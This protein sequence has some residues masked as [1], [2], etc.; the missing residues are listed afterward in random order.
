MSKID[1]EKS[2]EIHNVPSVGYGEI[3]NYVSNRTAQG[4]PALDALAQADGKNAEKLMEE[5]Q[6]NLELV[7]ETG[8]APE[9]RRNFGVISLLGVGFGL[10]NSWFGISASLVTGISSGGP[11]MIIYG[12]LIVACIS[13][14]VAISLSELIS[15]MPNA[16]GQYYWTMKLAPKKYAPFWAYMCGAFAWAGSV[17]TSASVTLS[18]ASSAVGMYMLYHPDKTIQTWHVFV[19]YEIANILLVFFNL[20]EKPLPAISKSSLY[21]S[22]LSFLIITIVVL[23]KSGGEFQSANF[24]F[25]EFTN[26]TGWSSSGIAFIVGLINPNW[27]FSCLD[28]ATHLA[29]ELLEPRK[30]IPIAIIGT[31]IIGFI[32]SFSYSIA[33][34]FCIKDLDAIYNSNTGVPI[35]DIFYQVLNN[36]AGAVILEFLIFLTA[37]GCNIA[38]HTWQARLCWSFARDNGLPGSRYWSKVNPRTGVPVNA[39]LMSCVWCAII[40]CIYMGSTTAYNAM[41][42]G[43]IIFLLMSYAVPVVF[44]LMKGRDNIKH[45]PFWLG[46]IGLFA[47]IVL[48]VW[49]VFTTIF[50]SFPPVM[51][52]TAGNMNYVSVVVGV[53]GAYCIIYW[54]ARGKK[55]FITAEDREAKIDELTH[56]LSQQISHIEV[57]LSHKNDV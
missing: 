2:T 5:A 22:L 11:M 10:T 52:V 16:G 44:L 12:I 40:G 54:F 47:N 7:Q 24:V 35:M 34:F 1:S 33:M 18:I 19:T 13:M 56:Q 3:Q 29:E 31:V 51:P 43:C 39:H 21:I 14:C 38:S 53:F 26:G 57:V 25:V 28:A 42:I 36:K 4:M 50:Y 27:S 30:Q 15:A 37:I 23:A 8:Y 46:K 6:A 55:K 48:L 41:V 45:G 32:T 17:F 49:T 20:W 9:L